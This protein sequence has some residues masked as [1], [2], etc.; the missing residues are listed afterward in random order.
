M[1][2]NI[3]PKQLNVES[4]EVISMSHFTYCRLTAILIGISLLNAITINPATARELVTI[5]DQSTPQRGLGLNIGLD[6]IIPQLNQR[7]EIRQGTTTNA[8][9]PAGIGITT[10]VGTLGIGV[11]VNKSLSVPKLISKHRI[12]PVLYCLVISISI[13]PIVALITIRN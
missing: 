4:A 3:L 12:K 9:Q 7:I 6:P 10:R 1:A 13:A 8:K 5:I 11:D 2:A